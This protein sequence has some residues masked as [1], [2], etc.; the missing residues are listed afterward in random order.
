MHDGIFQFNLLL[1][2]LHYNLR[3]YESS[4]RAHLYLVK[5]LFQEVLT[6]K[7][8]VSIFVRIINKYRIKPWVS[9]LW[10]VYRILHTSEFFMYRISHMNYFFK[11]INVGNN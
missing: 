1:K 11:I 10:E 6:N 8:Q 5:R 7:E 9:F 3:S 4:N 2:N